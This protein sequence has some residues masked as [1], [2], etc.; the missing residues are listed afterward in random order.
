MEMGLFQLENLAMT[1]TRFCL[2]DLRT[3][4]APISPTID[5]LLKLARRLSADEVLS[6][7]RDGRIS[8]E[9]PAILLC[10]D[11]ALSGEVA[12]R[13]ESAGHGQVYKVAGG[14][15]GLLSEL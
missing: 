13:M 4:I 12:R 9:T 1:P 5:R 3:Q 10:D 7:V 6:E 15:V 11:G 14:V 8:L 2:I